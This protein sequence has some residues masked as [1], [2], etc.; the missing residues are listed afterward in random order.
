MRTKAEVE[1]IDET[2]GKAK[3]LG[4]VFECPHCR[5]KSAYWLIKP[6]KKFKPSPP[7]F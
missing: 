2:V 5:K 1:L 6:S 4:F 7:V 3:R